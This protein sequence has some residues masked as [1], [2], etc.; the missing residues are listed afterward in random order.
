MIAASHMVWVGKTSLE[1]L[2]VFP[3]VVQQSGCVALL[4]GSKGGGKSGGTF[5]HAPQMLAE[6]LRHARSISIALCPKN[7]LPLM[8]FLPVCIGSS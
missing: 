5:C 8:S 7:R 2:G 3:Q 4:F 6:K 1:L